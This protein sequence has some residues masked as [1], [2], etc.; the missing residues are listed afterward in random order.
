MNNSRQ[1]GVYLRSRY[2][3]LKTDETS[4]NKGG[5]GFYT[6]RV[7]SVSQLWT[8]CLRETGDSDDME[9]FLSRSGKPLC[10]FRESKSV[11]LTLIFFLPKYDFILSVEFLTNV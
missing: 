9:Q 2:L 7:S 1:K 11:V 5:L 3:R 10:H 8:I 4:D 6:N